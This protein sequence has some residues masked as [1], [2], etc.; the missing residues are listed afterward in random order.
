MRERVAEGAADSRYI[1]FQ[2]LEANEPAID[3]EIDKKDPSRNYLR[4]AHI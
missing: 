2:A 1:V 4:H 3:E